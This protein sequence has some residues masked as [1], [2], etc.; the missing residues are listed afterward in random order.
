MSSSNCCFLTR[1]QI[2][3][4]AHIQLVIKLPSSPMGSSFITSLMSFP[5]TTVPQDCILGFSAHMLQALHKW[6]INLRSI[7]SILIK[8]FSKS[9]LIFKIYFFPKTDHIYWDT[10]YWDTLCQMEYLL[11][12][13]WEV[14]RRLL[15]AANRRSKVYHNTWASSIEKF[16]NF[17]SWVCK[18]A[19]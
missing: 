4:T 17:V 6:T 15:L 9:W 5:S 1:I 19:W 14:Q 13:S 7:R 16:G 10:L 11:S 12:G 3:L 2:S 18:R 8:L